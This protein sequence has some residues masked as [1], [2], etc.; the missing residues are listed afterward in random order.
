LWIWN[1]YS[2][3]PTPQYGNNFASAE[4]VEAQSTAREAQ[5]RIDLVSHDIERLLLITEALWMQMKKEHGYADDL[6][7]KLIEEIESRKVVVNGMAVKDPPQ[8]CPNC[9][10]INLAKRLICIYCGKPLLTHP[11]AT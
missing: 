7:P 4:A 2:I 3:S 8:P 1:L 6:L 10:K 5:T 9:G 11:F